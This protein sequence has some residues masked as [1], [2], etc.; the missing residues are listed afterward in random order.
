MHQCIHR[1]DPGAECG[2]DVEKPVALDGGFEF[3]VPVVAP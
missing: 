1:V 3:V 2:L